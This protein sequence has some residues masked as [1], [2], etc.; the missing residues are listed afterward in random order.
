MKQLSCATSATDAETRQYYT[1][2]KRIVR[3]RNF[4]RQIGV[5]IPKSS[6]IL[7]SFQ[8]NYQLPTPVFED[9]KGTRD[10]LAAGK[11]TS[12]LKHID[13]P[14]TYLHSLHESA[15]ITT[16]TAQSSTMMANFMTKQETGPQ[17]IKSTK[18][19]TGRQFYPPHSS[20]HFRLLTDITPLSLL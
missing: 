1:S 12:N 16:K 3:I 5:L 9:N 15:T 2:A 14:L 7:P 19:V 10:M 4:L 13:V 11:V 8:L 18:W 6:P 20:E 17:H